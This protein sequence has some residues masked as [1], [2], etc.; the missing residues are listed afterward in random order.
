MKT[1]NGIV[2]FNYW[3]KNWS[4]FASPLWCDISSPWANV[5]RWCTNTGMTYYSPPGRWTFY[6]RVFAYLC[7]V[8]ELEVYKIQVIQ[9][10]RRTRKRC[11]ISCN[12]FQQKFNCNWNFLQCYAYVTLRLGYSRFAKS[13]SKWQETLNPLAHINTNHLRLP[14]E[15][16]Y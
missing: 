9:S 1:A 15:M 7:L 6:T 12:S 11:F 4:S 5:S 16:L 3:L 13:P 10:C 14:K 2:S 8:G